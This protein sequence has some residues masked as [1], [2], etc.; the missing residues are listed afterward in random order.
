VLGVLPGAIG[1][2]QATEA[3]KILLDQGEPLVGRL[4]QYD[5][6]KMTFRTFKLRKDPECIVCGEKP[7][8]TDYIDYEGFCANLPDAAQ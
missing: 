7:T 4:L 2:L 6:L 8:V 1:T 3:V 5:S